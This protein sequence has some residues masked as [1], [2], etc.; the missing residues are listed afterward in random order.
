MLA[1]GRDPVLFGLVE[2][3]VAIAIQMYKETHAGADFPI[4]EFS[5]RVYKENAAGNESNLQ[6]V[7]VES[8]T[9]FAE[10][11]IVVLLQTGTEASTRRWVFRHSRY[12]DY[13]LALTFLAHKERLTQHISDRRFTSVYSLLGTMLPK[14]EAAALKEMIIEHSVSTNDITV[15][16]QFLLSVTREVFGQSE[17]S[18]PGRWPHA[19]DLS[20]PK[21]HGTHVA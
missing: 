3:Q 21:F 5:E 2:Q 16:R 20:K 12:R 19:D 13:F 1:A 14:A 15:L 17:K 4:S 10:H 8:M 18:A 11:R 9:S 6:T 7:M